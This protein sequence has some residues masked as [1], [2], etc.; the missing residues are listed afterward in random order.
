MRVIQTNV[1]GEV[2]GVARAIV[3]VPTARPSVVPRV[4]SGVCPVSNRVVTTAVDVE[5]SAFLTIEKPWM[6][7]ENDGTVT[8]VEV[9]MLCYYTAF[10]LYDNVRRTILLLLIGVP[11]SLARVV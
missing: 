7:D 3:V 6:S 1:T 10:V 9:E 8:A 5:Y 11:W 2:T 4:L